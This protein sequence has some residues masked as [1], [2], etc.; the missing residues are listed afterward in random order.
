[1]PDRSSSAP[2]AEQARP[3]ELPRAFE[4]TF[5]HAAPRERR[6]RVANALELIHRGELD[7]AGVFVIRRIEDLAGAI[8]CLPVPGASGLVWPPQTPE[9]APDSIELEDLLVATGLR[10]LRSR[11][12]KLVQSLLAEQESNLAEPLLRNGFAHVTSLWYMRHPLR[13][14]DLSVRNNLTL[15]KLA[16]ADPVLV[17]QT[18]LRSY[19]QSLDCPEVNG[20]RSIDE[21]IEGHRSQ[22]VHDPGRW[23]LATDRGQA[24]GVLLL[25][26]VPESS[27]MDLSY[28]GI[29][30]DARRRG[31]GRSLTCKAIQEAR[32]AGAV[33]LTLAVDVRNQPA[34]QLYRSLGFE[35]FERR[36]VYLWIQPS[37]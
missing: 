7:P 8:I 17:R 16:D 27:S 20:V 13:G 36:E 10:W 34:W 35:P 1:M 30:P 18:L 3:D 33:Q 21:I 23:W 25:A 19:E 2:S 15:Q 9:R 14:P 29:V 12:A 24:L 26:S 28:L 32:A 5:H 4:L 31:I 6:L 11:G 22:G 37:C